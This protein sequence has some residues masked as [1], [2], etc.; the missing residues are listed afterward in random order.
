M[1]PARSTSSPAAV[2]C[3]GHRNRGVQPPVASQSPVLPYFSIQH[4]KTEP[5]SVVYQ[6]SC[7]YIHSTCIHT[8]PNRT[9]IHTPTTVYYT[10]IH[11]SVHAQTGRPS[12]ELTSI[13]SNQTQQLIIA[14]HA[15]TNS[16]QHAHTCTLRTHTQY[17]RAYTRDP[18]IHPLY[19]Y[20][21]AEMKRG[22]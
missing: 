22:E 16:H 2:T 4:T 20:I 14:A 6:H 3:G 21:S 10:R 8:H 13:Q 11:A 5:N 19:V 12:T 15:T 17:I 9:Y 1:L 7:T 18:D